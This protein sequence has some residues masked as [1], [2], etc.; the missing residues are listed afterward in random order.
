MSRW[1]GQRRSCVVDR[2]RRRCRCCRRFRRCLLSGE[3]T[4]QTVHRFQAIGHIPHVAHRLPDVSVTVYSKDHQTDL[5]KAS[6]LC[7]LWRRTC[8]RSSSRCC[9]IARLRV[10]DPAKDML[11]EQPSSLRSTFSSY[12]EGALEAL[13]CNNNVDTR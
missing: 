5:P 10:I 13:I 6:R 7:G 12:I 2:G 11:I 1:R 9:R 3:A 4:V 8:W